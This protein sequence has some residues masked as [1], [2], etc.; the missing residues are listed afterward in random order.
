MTAL[1]DVAVLPLAR[2]P[3]WQTRMAALVE[4]RLALP[5]EWGSRDCCLWA[6]DVVHAVTG[7]DFGAA[8][9]GTYATQQEA[10]AVFVRMRGIARICTSL[11]GEPIDKEM[12]QP[13]D[14]GLTEEKDSPALVAYV[15]GAWMGQ[16]PDGLVPIHPESIATVWG[17]TCR[18][19]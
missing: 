9:R 13:G 4:A 7:V 11:L 19:Q 14:I 6:A 17:C 1:A 15:G 10:G 12:A 18:K 5:F 3:D 16:G 8:Y 2:L